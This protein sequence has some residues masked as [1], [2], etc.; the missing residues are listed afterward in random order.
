MS[1]GKFR[2]KESGDFPSRFDG[3]SADGK[4]IYLRWPKAFIANKT[5]VLQ[6][7]ALRGCTNKDSAIEEIPF[8]MATTAEPDSLF[9]NELLFD[10]KGD[11]FDFVEIY[12][13][14]QQIVDI[15]KLVFANADDTFTTNY[16]TLPMENRCL[17]PGGFLVLTENPEQVRN[18]YPQNDKKAFYATSS[19]P[20]MPNDEG[21]VKLISRLGRTLD[22]FHYL[23]NNHSPVL[24][25]PD[26]VS[27]E[28]SNPAGKKNDAT[29]WTSATASAGFAT[30]GIHN[31]Q[32]R[33][34]VGAKLH[35]FTLIGDA[36]TPDNDGN[37][38]LMTVAYNMPDAG[39][40]LTAKV[41]S[42]SGFLVAKPFVNYTLSQGGTI[43]WNGNT[44]RGVIL[45]GNYVVFLE[46]FNEKGTT[47]RQKLTVSVNRY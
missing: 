39:Y 5:V 3:I 40:Y 11:G 10:P 12:N 16:T 21:R 4:T 38:D 23:D 19:L 46:A 43:M 7:N 28:K 26:G 42:E 37:N 22:S 44:D 14:G 29:L 27:L 18:Q 15:S 20:S 24:A 6:V 47:I 34:I 36:F 13:A 32:L 2:L 33:L 41:Y 17:L 45:P 35:P 31:S 25:N 1:K 9:I 8:G 30:P